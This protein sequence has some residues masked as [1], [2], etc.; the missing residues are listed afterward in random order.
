MVEDGGLLYTGAFIVKKILTKVIGQTLY[1]GYLVIL[2][3]KGCYSKCSKNHL[4]L[5]RML[6]MTMI[7]FK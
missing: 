2:F 4:L 6:T 1:L 5:M 3:G 7:M